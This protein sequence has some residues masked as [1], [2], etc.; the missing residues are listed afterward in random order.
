MTNTLTDN[1]VATMKSVRRRFRTVASL[2]E[3]SG[4]G[5]AFLAHTSPAH[6]ALVE[7]VPALVREHRDIAN[8]ADNILKAGECSTDQWSAVCWRVKRNA[9]HTAAI[10]DELG[11]PNVPQPE[12]ADGD[13]A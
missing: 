12:P 8:L 1:Q 13:V 4:A 2:M 7:M 11:K 9:A 3:H 5:F 10:C 6:R